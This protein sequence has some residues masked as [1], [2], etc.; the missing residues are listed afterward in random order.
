MCYSG[1]SFGGNVMED[2]LFN[3]GLKFENSE[4]IEEYLIYG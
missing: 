4:G 3:V 1:Y 2:L